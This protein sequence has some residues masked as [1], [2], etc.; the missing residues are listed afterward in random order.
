MSSQLTKKD[1]ITLL[2][3]NDWHQYYSTTHWVHPNICDYFDQMPG[4]YY[5]G[6]EYTNHQMTLD[7]AWEIYEKFQ[8]P[9]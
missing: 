8:K 7:E 9:K 5:Y 2:V 3:E 6:R 4:R 1:K